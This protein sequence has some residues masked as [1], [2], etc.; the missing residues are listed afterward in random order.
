MHEPRERS[1]FNTPSLRTHGYQSEYMEV[2]SDGAWFFFQCAWAH[3]LLDELGTRV[4]PYRV[5]SFQFETPSS[6]G[7]HTENTVIVN[8]VVSSRSSIIWRSTRS[9]V[10]HRSLRSHDRLSIF[11]RFITLFLPPEKYS[12]VLP[13]S[14]QVFSTLI[15]EFSKLGFIF[16][17]GL[18][19]LLEIIYQIFWS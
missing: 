1:R 6:I 17:L 7:S 10:G 16:T 12:Q 2:E 15:Q 19:L 11:E 5:A 3:R 8:H 14:I 18:T 9:W 4:K 13:T